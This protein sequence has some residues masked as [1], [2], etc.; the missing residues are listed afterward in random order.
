VSKDPPILN[1]KQITIKRCGDRA[2]YI[3]PLP[4]TVESNKSC[5]DSQLQAVIKFDNEH[6]CEQKHREI[7]LLFQL[8]TPVPCAGQTA[9]NTASGVKEIIGPRTIE[10][11]LEEV[12]QDLAHAIICRTEVVLNVRA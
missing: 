2:V 8:R 12:A 5:V 10:A 11:M 6:T 4:I 3:Q 1:R 9:I 7:P